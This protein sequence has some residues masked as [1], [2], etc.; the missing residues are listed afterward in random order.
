MTELNARAVLI[1]SLVDIVGSFVVGGIFFAVI[2]TASG[3]T[4]AEELN[5]VYDTSMT[6]Q[7][8]TLVLGLAMTGVG[9][10]VAARMTKGTERL[11]AFAVGVIST[12][13]GFTV[14]FAAPET[15]PFWSQAASLILTIPAAF[16]GG[17]I[18]RAMLGRGRRPT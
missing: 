15:Q 10:Y 13:I 6:F 3:A 12:A 4:T 2:G 17:E 1:G 14:V 16:A 18:R 8:V 9:A 11:H 7:L 5:T